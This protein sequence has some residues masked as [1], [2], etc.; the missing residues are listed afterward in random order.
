[1]T[2]QEFIS[3]I[4]PAAVESMARTKIPASFVIAEAALE[5]GWGGHAPG[6]NLFG[7]K[8]DASWHGAVTI[9][10]TRE[11]V[12]SKSVFIDARFRAYTDWLGSI[13]DHAGFL[14]DMPRYKPAFEHC[15]D[16]KAFTIAVADEHYATAPDYAKK[17]IEVIDEHDLQQYDRPKVIA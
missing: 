17:I 7:V 6:M 4:A 10:R 8:A 14:L 2:P 12:D 15:D 13:T 9:Q 1:M 5:S 11:V 16:S 3:A